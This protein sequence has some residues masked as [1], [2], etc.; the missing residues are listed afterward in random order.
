MDYFEFPFDNQVVVS[1]VI[2]SSFILLVVYVSDVLF[3]S[4]SKV[5]VTVFISFFLKKYLNVFSKLYYKPSRLHFTVNYFFSNYPSNT[6]FLQVIPKYPNILVDI[7]H[8]LEMFFCFNWKLGGNFF[9]CCNFILFFN[10]RLDIITWFITL[11]VFCYWST[12]IKW[13]VFQWILLCR[14]MMYYWNKCPEYCRYT[15][16]DVSEMLGWLNS[17]WIISRRG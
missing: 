17:I 1:F 8:L 12:I 11:V 9:I 13:P 4:L 14:R 10:I 2:L 7:F 15:T 3:T 6:L 16:M 5:W